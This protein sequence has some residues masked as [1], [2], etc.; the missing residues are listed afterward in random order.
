MGA[1]LELQVHCGS[2][3]YRIDLRDKKTIP[4]IF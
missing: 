2:G 1:L 4:K 3:D